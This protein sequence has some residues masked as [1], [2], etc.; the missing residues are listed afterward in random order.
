MPVESR[1]S[2][3]MAEAFVKTFKRDY[4]RINPLPDAQTA[5]SRIS[6]DGGLQRRTP[7]LRLGYRSPG[8]STSGGDERDV[9]LTYQVMSSSTYPRRVQYG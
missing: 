8:S 4:V 7:A 3:G 9:V 5:F 6:L 1:D 2:N